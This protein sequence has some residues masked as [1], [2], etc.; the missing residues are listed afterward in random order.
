[1]H[2]TCRSFIGP[3]QE[4]SWSQYWENEPD[5]PVLSAKRGHLFGLAGFTASPDAEVAL[6]GR[7]L[8]SRINQTYYSPT[9]L[10]PSVWIREVVSRII[11]QQGSQY[12]DLSLILM[13]VIKKEIYLA[14]YHPV[15]VILRRHQ[16]ISPIL[17][18]NDDID[19]ITGSINDNDRFLLCTDNFYQQFTWEKIKTFLNYDNV[20]DIEE[21]FLSHLYSLNQ[22][23]LLAAALIQVN[24]DPADLV[25]NSLP[26]T[27]PPKPPAAPPPPR[28]SF[29]KRLF[30]SARPVYISHQDVATASR[31][32]RANRILA[33]IILAALTVSVVYGSHRNHT[34]SLENQ[35][36]TLKTEFDQKINNAQALKN[37][38]LTDAQAVAREARNLLNQMMALNLHS[39]ETQDLIGK[40]D[41]LLAQTGS[42]DS[43]QPQF[44]YDTTNI[45]DQASYTQFYL[46]GNH[47]Y[48]LDPANSRID[49]LDISNKSQQMVS[50]SP[51]LKDT[52]SMAISNDL[53]YVLANRNIYL[54]N[55][56]TLVSKINITSSL[57]DFQTGIFDFWSGSLY[58]LSLSP[59]S[60]LWKYPPNASGF[61]SGSSWINS[62]QSLP[63]DVASFAINGSIWLLSSSGQLTPYDRGVRREFTLPKIDNADG[64][65]NNLV[66]S[67]D[68]DILAF[69]F[70]KHFVYIYRKDGTPVASYNFQDKNILD[71]TLSSSANLIFVLCHDHQIYQIPF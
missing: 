33:L 55:Q 16:K 65:A 57:N 45:N 31:R 62:N 21:N 64:S 70:G 27:P 4:N 19:L 36:Q 20:Q 8:I 56:D 50:S 44:F 30:S 26:E 35:Y 11:S 60:N 1:M 10:A 39:D 43:Y 71:L 47:L 6:M 5:D 18:G 46:T 53:L 22:I 25:D 17:T 29:L 67:A 37:I 48:L 54:V 14:T 49:L 63:D 23:P 7:Q 68:S 66:T 69:T 28:S 41:D 52:V 9:Q 42:S 13:V 38:N 2:F 3:P 15:H 58:L 40:T 59:S 51:L 24:T 34:R 12:R 61:S 32:K